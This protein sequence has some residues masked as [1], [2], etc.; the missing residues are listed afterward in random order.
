M[1]DC[2]FA[3][4]FA[5]VLDEQNNRMRELIAK[6]EEFCA[7]ADVSHR[8]QYLEQLSNQYTM[9][10]ERRIHNSHVGGEADIF[11]QPEIGDA[12][13]LGDNVDLF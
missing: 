13:D 2:V 3:V 1:R 5:S 8:P 7:G 9:D 11:K 4:S 6:A 12:D 10:S